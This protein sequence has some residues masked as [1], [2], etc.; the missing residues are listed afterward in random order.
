[1]NTGDRVGSLPCMY[2]CTQSFLDNQLRF[3]GMLLDEQ[4]GF[5]HRA[6]E[7]VNLVLVTGYPVRP[8]YCIPVRDDRSE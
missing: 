4:L 1:M 2:R 5:S 7:T 8:D 6:Q 3:G